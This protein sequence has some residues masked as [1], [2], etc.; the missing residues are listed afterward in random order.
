SEN[1]TNLT[2]TL[3]KVFY[4]SEGS[5]AV[6]IAMKMSLHSRQLMDQP[7]KTRFIALANGYHGETL[8]AL[9]VS[10]L[11]LYKQPYK[12]LLFPVQFIILCIMIIKVE[13]HFCI[14]IPFQ[15][16]L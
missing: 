1:L 15:E 8:G 16:A 9:S 7:Q 10:D 12:S 11:G 14:H 4:A 6:E 13:K 2:T 5:S 3:K